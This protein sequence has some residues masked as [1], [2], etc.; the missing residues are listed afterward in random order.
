[1]LALEGEF[2]YQQFAR[3]K[4]LRRKRTA[5]IAP[6]GAGK[7]RPIVQALDELGCL[8]NPEF[9]VLVICSGPAIATWDRQIPLWAESGSD[10][11]VEIVRG[12]KK[13]R[14]AHW[15]SINANVYVT[16]FSIFLRDFDLIRRIPWS[17]VVA[18]EYHKTMRRR[19]SKTYRSFLS[20]TRKLPVVVLASGSLV[21]RDASSMFTAFQIIH[22]QHF[23]SYWRFVNTFCWVDDTGFGKRV[24]GVRNARALREL[25]D[26]YLAYIP[27][28]VVADQLPE[29]RRVRVAA[30]MTPK[31]LRAYKLVE[32][33]MMLEVNK[34]KD[35]ILT[36][37]VL[38]KLVLLRQILCCPATVDPELGMGGGF[39]V[40]WD[41]LEEDP[42]VVIFVPFRNACDELQKELIDRNF[43]NTFIIR[44]GVSSEDQKTIIQQF[45]ETEGIL[46]CTIQYAESF[47]LASCKTAWFLGYDLTVDQNEQAEGRIRRAISLHRFVQ[48]KYITYDCSVDNHFLAKLNEDAVNAKLILR[49]PEDF[50]R[51]LKGTT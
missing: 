48:W 36:S 19:K 22:P 16:N 12:N 2:P 10:K 9:P 42:H 49:R 47:D 5:V 33:E 30:E 28:E 7:T 20:L 45:E 23:S 41:Q 6:P 1:M 31:Q 50:I 27:P 51:A 21:R 15:L 44:G 38:A 18:D 25:M 32:N 13:Q 29:G 46:I 39:E 17:A 34:G 4:I 14:T 26:R 8:G 3:H 37:T 24:Y 40:L 35:I 43:F 11:I